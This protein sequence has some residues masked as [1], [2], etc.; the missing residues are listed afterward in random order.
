MEYFGQL[1]AL[2]TLTLKD[3]FL[4]AFFIDVRRI[5]VYFVLMGQWVLL[6]ETLVSSKVMIEVIM[7]GTFLLGF[8]RYTHFNYL[9]WIP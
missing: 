2:V 6:F 5:F 1:A 4:L 8:I 9:T 3:I 7:A